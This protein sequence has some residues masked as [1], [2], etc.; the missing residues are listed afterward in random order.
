MFAPLSV[1]M[2]L[3]IGLRTGRW[4]DAAQCAGSLLA[5]MAVF[6]IIVSG[7]RLVVTDESIG[8]RFGFSP[9]RRMYFRD[10]ASSVP[11]IVGEPDWPITLA[12]YAPHS[13]RPAMWVPLKPWRQS[14]VKWLLTLPQLKLEQPIRSLTKRGATRIL[15]GR[16]EA[17]VSAIP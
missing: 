2:F 14:D 4:G 6:F 10:I 9:M 15:K 3:L 8:Y 13:R 7:N 5:I 11:V 17:D 12:I 1:A 16:D